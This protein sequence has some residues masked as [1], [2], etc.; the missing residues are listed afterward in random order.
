MRWQWKCLV[1]NLK[2]MVPFGSYLRHRKYDFIEYR[3]I[4]GRADWALE[5]GLQQL[6]WLLGARSLAGA[7]VLEIGTGW[8]PIIPL[9]Y[10]I[11]GASR[12]YLT[13]LNRLCSPGSVQGAIDTV[14]RNKAK[15]VARLGADEERYRRAVEW[16]PAET[17]VDPGFERIGLTYLA[18]CDCQKLD[19]PFASIDVISSRAVLEHIPPTVIDGIHK[20]SYRLLKPDGHYCHFVDPSDHWQHR[21]RSIT[22]INFLGFSDFTNYLT[23]FGGMNFQNRL[24]HSDYVRALKAAGYRLIR[25][26]RNVDAPGLEALRTGRVKPA[27]RFQGYTLEDLA[28]VDSFLFATK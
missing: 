7:T 23:N 1:D 3:S 11:A 21:D 4:Q 17:G 10:S 25:E 19:L 27:P 5:E 9:L 13:D 16:K 26:E 2:G 20:E 18:P 22:R 28:T 14:V 12:V 8:E 15:V 24:R 6:E